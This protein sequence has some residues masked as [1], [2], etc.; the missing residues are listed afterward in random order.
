MSNTDDNV[1]QLSAALDATAR[2]AAAPA[3]VDTLFSNWLARGLNNA[4]STL[5]LLPSAAQPQTWFSLFQLQQSALQKLQQQQNIWVEHWLGWL[6]EAEK[7]RNANTLSKLLEQECNLAM[8]A[9]QIVG[10]YAV[11]L[12]DLQE[13][14]EVNYGYWAQL[15]RSDPERQAG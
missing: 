5:A 12:S 8:Q 7:L 2:N 13:N 4:G 10:N 11:N 3:K 1:R 9:V 14:L 15:Q 6:G